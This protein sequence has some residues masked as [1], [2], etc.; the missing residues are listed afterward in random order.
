MSEPITFGTDGWR[1]VI[2]EHFTFDNVRRVSEAIAVAAR[3]LQPPAGIDRNTLVVGY[4]RRFLSREFAVTVA[5]VLRTA[6]YR[7]IL[8]KQPTPSQTSGALG[9]PPPCR[10]GRSPRGTR[11]RPG[12]GASY[13]QRGGSAPPG[14]GRRD[15]GV[16][17]GVVPAALR[18]ALICSR[19]RIRVLA[20]RFLGSKPFVLRSPVRGWR[21][22]STRARKRGSERTFS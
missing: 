2:A 1:A 8:S 10:P 13:R 22:W 19:T 6:G 16:G 7:V 20:H 11:S 17:A 15:G 5:D 9:K 12:S 18:V 14:S 21:T 3:T 4:D